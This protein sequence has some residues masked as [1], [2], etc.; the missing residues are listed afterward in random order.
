MKSLKE[1]REIMESQF[2][3]LAEANTVV[4]SVGVLVDATLMIIA[5]KIV[6]TDIVPQLAIAHLRDMAAKICT[7]RGRREQ[8]GAEQQIELGF[9]ILQKYYQIQRGEENACVLRLS[10]DGQHRDDLSR[11]KRE[12]IADRLEKEANTKLRHADLLRDET[13]K[14]VNQGYFEFSSTKSSKIPSVKI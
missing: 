6:R 7:Q 13:V 1:V 11:E 2:D 14:L 10:P 3:L 5:P 9:V 12:M 8:E 4:I